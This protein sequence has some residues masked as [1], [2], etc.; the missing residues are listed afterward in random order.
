MA[1]SESMKLK[2]FVS[3]EKLTFGRNTVF[4]LR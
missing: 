3:P 1:E 2:F 4:A